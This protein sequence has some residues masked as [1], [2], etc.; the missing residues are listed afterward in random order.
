[1]ICHL[2]GHKILNKTRYSF[3]RYY[4]QIL[5]YLRKCMKKFNIIE[6]FKIFLHKLGHEY[7]KRIYKTAMPYIMIDVIWFIQWSIAA[8]RG[9]CYILLDRQRKIE[10]KAQKAK[11]KNNRSLSFH[12][13]FLGLSVFFRI[14]ECS[15]ISHESLDKLIYMHIIRTSSM[16]GLKW[17]ALFVVSA[18]ISRVINENVRK[19][20]KMEI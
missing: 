8:R 16:R 3:K 7:A 15:L 13:D 4:F 12:F 17:C 9:A 6:W 1:M 11:S 19:M 14:F 2:V 18:Y 20:A 5:R 10:N